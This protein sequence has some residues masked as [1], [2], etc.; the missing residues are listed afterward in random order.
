M[1][2]EK[3]N[4]NIVLQQIF[5]D[6]SR[7]SSKEII[8]HLHDNEY[9]LKGLTRTYSG[10]IMWY[11]FVDGGQNNDDKKFNI[12]EGIQQNKLTFRSIEEGENVK[13]SYTKSG[14]LKIDFKQPDSKS[15][16]NESSILSSFKQG[17]NVKLEKTQDGKLKISVLSNKEI[18]HKN[19]K[20]PKTNI[21]L[22]HDRIGLG[23]QP[24]YDY[25]L[26]IDLEKD[27]A[28]NAIHIGDGTYGLTL[29][30]GTDDGFLPQLI[31]VGDKEDDAGIYLIGKSV[32]NK[33]SNT[34]LIILDGRDRFDNELINRPILGVT[35]ADY[36]KYKFLINY[37]GKITINKKIGKQRLEVGGNI[38]AQ[39]FVL[40]NNLSVQDL[41]NIIRDQ[42][43]KIDKLY[44]LVEKIL[45]NQKK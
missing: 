28:K 29:G 4:T 22:K 45:L 15:Y 32:K 31:G 3:D 35:S 16:I 42:Q 9:N 8:P 21:F 14:N 30:N 36:N 11:P 39:D 43:Y 5:A 19:G 24:L 7:K 18:L 38:K 27:K 6:R 10:N 41:F 1:I 17:E 12:F 33:G 26:D 25:K 44:E 20:F 34:P 23:R 13:L 37:D 2:N 40:N